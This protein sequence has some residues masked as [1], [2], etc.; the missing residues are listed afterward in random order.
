M[1]EVLLTGVVSAAF[2][3]LP[4]LHPFSKIAPSNKN[5]MNDKNITCLPIG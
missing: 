1:A 5:S 4:V 3:S 2:F